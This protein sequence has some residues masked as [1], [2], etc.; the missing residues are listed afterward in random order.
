[1]SVKVDYLS[2][3]LGISVNMLALTIDV[4]QKSLEKFEEDYIIRR[5]DLLFDFVKSLDNIAF[6]KEKIFNYLFMPIDSQEDSPT[7][8]FY[9]IHVG[10][11]GE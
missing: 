3:T 7:V 4:S 8:L 10:G 5:I 1:M 2:R 11:K 9:I 6:P